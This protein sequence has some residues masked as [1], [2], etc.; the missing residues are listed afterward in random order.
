MSIESKLDQGQILRD[1]HDLDE[2]TLKVS[3]LNSL[4]SKKY[5]TIEVTSKTGFGPTSIVYR[6]G[7]LSG[8]VVA[9]SI[10]TYDIDGDFKSIEVAQ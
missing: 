10:I 6:L 8:T 5:D 4:V 3:N 2:G 9:V 7:G 1:V